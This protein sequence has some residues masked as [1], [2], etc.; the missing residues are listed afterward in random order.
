MTMFSTATLVSTED[1]RS[2]LTPALAQHMR[3]ADLEVML[4]RELMLDD[5]T[6]RSGVLV[7]PGGVAIDGDLLLDFE[8]AIHRG[9]GFR[10]IVALGALEVRGDI[11]NTNCDGGP[12]LVVLGPLTVRHIIKGGAAVAVAGPLASS[13]TIYCAYNHG[14]FRA[15]GG[16]KA[17]AIIVDDHL[18][19]L[20]G[21]IDAIRLVL[22]EEDP[23]AYLLPELLWEE[24]GVPMDDLGD[25]L[26]ARIKA[27]VPIFRTD[28]PRSVP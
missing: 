19:E 2:R 5:A 22:G 13:G 20:A 23:F 11:L 14:S 26:I 10:G 15:W 18:F 6:D 9:Q 1:A 4:D 17:E 24:E 16:L 25:E 3:G 7:L 12:F 28:A 27:G 8:T 21:P